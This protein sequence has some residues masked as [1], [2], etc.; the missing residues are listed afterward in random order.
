MANIFTHFQASILSKP[1]LAE[2]KPLTRKPLVKTEKENKEYDKWKNTSKLAQM[3]CYL[4]EECQKHQS[5]PR[6]THDGI[7]F[8]AGLSARGFRLHP[9]LTRFSDDHVKFLFAFLKER[10]VALDYQ[11]V[12]S[13]TSVFKRGDY[14]VETI[15]RHILKSPN[16]RGC[17]GENLAGDFGQ[18]TIELLLKD[19]RLC[20]LR[21]E[22]TI[23]DTDLPRPTD[24]FANLI[25]LLP[26]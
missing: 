12:S 26:A 23:P 14:W 9:A 10:L 20:S 19:D 6:K 24:D 21:F 18:I 8:Y 16:A 15:H 25:Q 4:S 22:A 13:D 7:D 5:S 1:E 17:Y 11:A 3:L 2:T